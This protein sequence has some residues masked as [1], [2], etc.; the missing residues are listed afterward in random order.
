M[1]LHVEL[2]LYWCNSEGMVRSGKANLIFFGPIAPAVE[3]INTFGYD[4]TCQVATHIDALHMEGPKA[5]VT[6]THRC[7]I[8]ERDQ[9]DLDR[10]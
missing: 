9:T 7:Y 2:D 8:V 4:L 10:W 6:L 1:N 3:A 5:V